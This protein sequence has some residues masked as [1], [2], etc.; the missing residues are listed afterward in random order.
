MAGPLKFLI[1]NG[2]GLD[3]K[4]FDGAKR[5]KSNESHFHWLNIEGRGWGGEEQGFVS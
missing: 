1:K 3:L 4:S 2:S 5:R